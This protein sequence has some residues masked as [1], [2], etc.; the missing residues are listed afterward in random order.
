MLNPADILGPDGRIAARLPNYEVRQPQLR[1]ADAVWDALREQRHLIV[2][3]G[4]G[5]GKSFAYLVPAILAATADQQPAPS[6]QESAP[7]DQRQAPSGQEG[8]PPGQEG[9]PPGP[10]RL[11][12]V[13]IS[14]HTISLQEQLMGKDIPLLNSVIPRE[15][16]AVLAKGRGNYISLRRLKNAVKRS[17]SLFSDDEQFEQLRQI[18]DWAGQ[19][20]DG[21]LSDLPFRPQKSVWDEVASD[22]GNCMG[23]SCPRH[24]DCFYFRARRR[25]Q[26]AQLLIVNHALLCSDLALRRVGASILPDYGAVILDEAHT[27]EDV[28]GDH[29]GIRITWG[30]VRYLLNK[31]F[32]PRNGK[33]LLA[34]EKLHAA[35]N[36]VDACWERAD[37]LFDDIH[38]WYDTQSGSGR[39]HDPEIVQNVLS[40]ELM[41]LSEMVKHYG[42]T[43]ESESERQ[44]YMSAHERLVGIAQQLEEWRRQEIEDNVYW[45][46]VEPSSRGAPR[47][48]LSAAPLDVSPALRSSLFSAVDSVIL[49]S[50]TLSVG[51][52]ANFDFFKSRVGLTQAECLRLGSPFNYREQAELIILRG[53]PDPSQRDAFERACGAM[54]QRY[55]ARTDGRAFVLFTS[56]QMMRTVGSQLRGWLASEN[57]Q[58]Y[59]QSDGAPRHQMLEDFRRHPRSVLFGTDSFWQGVDVPGDALQNVIITRLPFAVPGRPLLEARLD[60]IRAG[61]GN[62]FSE[63]QL[64]QAV[65][66]LRQG[67]GRLI[68]TQ[69]DRGMVVLLDPRVRTKYYGR[70]FL[71]SLPDCRV[72]EEDFE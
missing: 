66:K 54:I 48:S 12:R 64:P 37:E 38:Q 51:R 56:Y 16:T 22:S 11:R 41:K 62:P 39:V 70:V 44:D 65:I 46:D 21:S 53:M 49:T 40:P 5:V 69:Q 29:F 63:Y 14:T 6:D 30:Q 45:I 27:L 67:F 4:T 58:L 59:S 50:A 47:I 35:R 13:V 36:Q 23:R 25:L 68:R 32:N 9:A 2:E 26:N 57:L 28:A 60:A 72:V 52:D 42:Q 71:D 33:G 17:V 3:A 19:T 20:G 34:A 7:P 31:L 10:K 55:V 15:F 61:G 43:M 24:G 1:M 8:E 18:R